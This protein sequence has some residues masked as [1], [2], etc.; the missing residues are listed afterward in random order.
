MK[1]INLSTIIL[2]LML[3]CTRGLQAGVRS[4]EEAMAIA[5]RFMAESKNDVSPAERTKRAMV[6]S[7]DAEPMQLAYT[8]KVYDNS[9]AAVYVFTHQT[10]GF[11][12]VSADDRTRAILGYSDGAFDAEQMPENMRVWMQ[13]YADEIARLASSAKAAPSIEDVV[14]PHCGTTAGQYR[15]EPKCAI[16]RPLS[17]RPKHQRAFGDRLYGYGCRTSDVSP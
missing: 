12:L 17:Y 15:M 3:V 8:Q 16:Q 6:A 4:V 11:V 7:L 1:R 14:L 2:L 9:Q 13:M 5:G 10:D